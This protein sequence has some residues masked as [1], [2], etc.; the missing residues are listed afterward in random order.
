MVLP[1]KTKRNKKKPAVK[2]AATK[3][4]L[5]ANK[6]KESAPVATAAF[7]KRKRSSFITA[8]TVVIEHAELGEIEATVFQTEFAGEVFKAK[9][10]ALCAD[11][12][13]KKLQE[14]KDARALERESKKANK[15][16]EKAKDK[17]VKLRMACDG[18]TLDP[19]LEKHSDKINAIGEAIQTLFSAL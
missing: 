14:Q 16:I 4:P 12:R 5:P 7:P 17:L 1:V 18:L 3:K 11:W 9:T 6:K 10:R 13:A 15:R 2:K 8:T 19:V